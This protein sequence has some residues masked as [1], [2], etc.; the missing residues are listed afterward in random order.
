MSAQIT[1]AVGEKGGGAK[2]TTTMNL[3]VQLTLQ[4]CKVLVADT[5]PQ[6]TTFKWGQRR[7]SDRTQPEI[8]VIEVTARNLQRFLETNAEQYDHILLDTGGADSDGMRMAL[9]FS[10][11]VLCPCEP[12]QADVET[13]EHVN[14]LIGR[15][16]VENPSMIA[17]VFATK[18]PTHIH[19]DDAREMHEFCAN[20]EHLTLLNTVVGFRKAFKNALRDGLAVIEYPVSEFTRKAIEEAVELEREIFR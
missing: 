3:A 19:A 15:A 1:A 20:F 16:K 6:R 9:M 7:K 14:T 12:S 13:L 10:D 5:D 17:Y 11:I 8:E 18:A 4:G 2:S